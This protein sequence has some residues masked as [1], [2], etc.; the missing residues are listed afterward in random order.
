MGELY[1]VPDYDASLIDNALF[2]FTMGSLEEFRLFL[3]H[4]F[5]VNLIIN[6]E[7]TVLAVK[8]EYSINHTDLPDIE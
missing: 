7:Y 8:I 2:P 1:C 4:S 6:Q 3:P 5:K